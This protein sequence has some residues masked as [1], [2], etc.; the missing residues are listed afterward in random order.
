MYDS[1]HSP[2][3]PTSSEMHRATARW[4]QPI[5]PPAH[6]SR[7]PRLRFCSLLRRGE[8]IFVEQRESNLRPTITSERGRMM[9]KAPCPHQVHPMAIEV[10]DLAR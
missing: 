8:M 5:H 7:P 10:H 2:L 3:L 1:R 9:P 6:A 4:L